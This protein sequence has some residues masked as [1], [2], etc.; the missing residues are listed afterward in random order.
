MRK[1]A[2]QEFLGKVATLSIKG[3]GLGALTSLLNELKYYERDT[4]KTGAPII[5]GGR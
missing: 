1:T 4:T 2:I 3:G 5:N